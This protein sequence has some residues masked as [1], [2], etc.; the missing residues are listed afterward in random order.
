MSLIELIPVQGLK[1]NYLLAI[2][3]VLLE[4]VLNTKSIWQVFTHTNLI[5]C[6]V[7]TCHLT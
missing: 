4:T 1:M 2:I 6:F 3:S 5:G 7:E